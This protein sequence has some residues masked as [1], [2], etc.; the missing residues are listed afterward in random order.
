MQTRSGPPVLG[1]FRRRRGFF[2]E[3]D[4][5][6]AVLGD[7]Y[8]LKLNR[9]T[10]INMWSSR[11]LGILGTFENVTQIDWLCSLTGGQWNENS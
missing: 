3:V 8:C 6:R 10:F 1:R 7:N 4:V 9:R 2:A 5:L 11:A